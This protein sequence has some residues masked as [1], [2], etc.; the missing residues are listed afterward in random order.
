MP[1]DVLNCTCYYKEKKE[2]E[3]IM[4]GLYNYYHNMTEEE[5]MQAFTFIEDDEKLLLYL[6]CSYNNNKINKGIM[7]LITNPDSFFMTK[8]EKDKFILDFKKFLFETVETQMERDK[9]NV[10]GERTRVGDN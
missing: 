7:S 9:L 5:R 4:K 8:E 6:I 10:V 1:I 3:V 2:G